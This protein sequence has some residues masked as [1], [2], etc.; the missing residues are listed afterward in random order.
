MSSICTKL[1]PTS[2]KINKIPEINVL[3]KFSPRDLY[4]VLFLLTAQIPITPGLQ[5]TVKSQATST[6][7]TT[8][9]Y[10]TPV[11]KEND[12][13]NEPEIL[14]IILWAVAAIGAIFVIGVVIWKLKNRRQPG[15]RRKHITKD[16][17]SSG[18]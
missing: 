1:E 10:L 18:K 11:G 15:P 16:E 8:R 7:H 2:S 12:N 13:E 17:S 4:G 5:A 14:T 3:Q 9:G 6:T